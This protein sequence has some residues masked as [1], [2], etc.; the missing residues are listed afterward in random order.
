[1]K[2]TIKKDG[3]LRITPETEIEDY[4]LRVWL[5]ENHNPE[6]GTI[7]TNVLIFEPLPTI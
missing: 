5:K 4:A 3:T 2:A 7:L 1:M 6:H